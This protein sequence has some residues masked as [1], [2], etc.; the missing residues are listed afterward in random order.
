MCISIPNERTN[1]SRQ[2]LATIGEV[3]DCNISVDF[4]WEPYFPI[5]CVTL[6][7]AKGGTGKSGFM[8]WLA[9]K[10]AREQNIK[11]MYIDAENTLSHIRDR[12]IDWNFTDI[13][14]KIFVPLEYDELGNPETITPT[15]STITAQA[16]DH[17]VKLIVIDSLTTYSHKSDVENRA[18]VA[19]LMKEIRSIAVGT[20]AAVVLLGHL[21]KDNSDQDI[22]YNINQISGSAALVDLSRSVLLMRSEPCCPENKIIRHV[23]SNYRPTGYDLEMTFTLTGI[24][25]LREVRPAKDFNI[26]PRGTKTDVYRLQAEVLAKEGRSKKL[27]RTA[28]KELGGSEI[29]ATRTI[30]WLKEQ[31]YRFE[32]A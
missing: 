21:N 23:K 9:G 22:E 14:D 4:L 31:G 10:L 15:T 19:T 17:G 8:L 13:K 20:Q 29:E 32:E 26:I 5:G 7:A 27:I 6:L 24:E 16:K 25:N 12:L 11:T 30:K 28:V 3:M 2:K 1:M 18:A